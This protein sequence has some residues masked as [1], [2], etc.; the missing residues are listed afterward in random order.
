MPHAI[1]LWAASSVRVNQDTPAMESTA[2]V[3]L[4]QLKQD[5]TNLVYRSVEIESLDSQET[6]WLNWLLATL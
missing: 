1:T 3:Q 2:Q 6:D 5:Y 4:S